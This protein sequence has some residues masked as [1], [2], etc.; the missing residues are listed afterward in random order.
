MDAIPPEIW[1]EIFS[2]ACTDDGSTGRALSRVSRAVQIIS[3]SSKYQSICVLGP[4]QL[5]KLFG[6][7]SALSPRARKVKYLF[8]ACLDECAEF[9][10][11]DHGAQTIRQFY[12]NTEM[13]ATGQALEQ[14]LQLVSPSLVALQIH[15]TKIY[16]QSVLLDM[17]FPVLSELTLHGPFKST[18]PRPPECLFPNLRRIHIHHFVHH[19]TQ[20]LQQIVRV[21]PKITH[22]H[23]PQRSFSAYDIQV[24]LGIL[25]PIVS[26][27]ELSQLPDSLQQLV[28][29]LEPAPS[30]LDSWASNIR[31]EQHR[32][33][34]H[35]IS[36][37]DARIR[38]ADGR[39]DWIPVVEA[40]ERWIS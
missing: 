18:D 24:A 13:N 34:F 2:F 28:I 6:L 25:Q 3:K 8:V 30:S 26:S 4:N 22:L 38:L 10:G 12:L 31:G 16:R 19:P 11:A 27:S 7:L 33:K 40:K 21:A 37:R 15:R 20:F 1:S 9:G 23:V 29:E 36:Q 39:D 35:K 32:R 5:L 14:L 17:E